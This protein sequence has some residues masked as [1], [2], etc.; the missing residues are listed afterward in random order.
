[1]TT[2]M[3]RS[4]FNSPDMKAFLSILRERNIQLKLAGEELSVKFPK[5][6]ADEGILAEIRANKAALINY[7]KNLQRKEQL[8]IPV[9]AAR[10]DYGLSS[11]QQ[12]LWS[13]CQVPEINAA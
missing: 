7:L 11:S 1:M 10:A 5:G 13:L 4:K 3:T 12:R 2:A 9:L 6:K 8:H